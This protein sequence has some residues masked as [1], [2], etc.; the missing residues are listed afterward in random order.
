MTIE[1]Y[2]IGLT[3]L[4]KDFKVSL[5]HQD[6]VEEENDLLGSISSPY[7]AGRLMHQPALSLCFLR[8]IP[9]ANF[10]TDTTSV[11]FQ[12]PRVKIS[13]VVG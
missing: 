11:A 5:V 10:I 2:I 13:L 12:P 7:F 3:G 6:L 4:V 1:R 9:S 8:G